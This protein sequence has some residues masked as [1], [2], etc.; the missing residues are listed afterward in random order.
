MILRRLTTALRKQDWVTVVIETLIVVFG[1]F[2]G[3]QVNNWNEARAERSA[4]RGTLIRLH[5]DFRESIAGQ[6]RDIHFLEQQLADQA[7]ILKSLDACA[8]APGDDAAFQRGIATIGWINPPRL[9]RR[10]IDE[11]TASG[12]TD[13]ISSSEIAEELAR[14]IALV[15]WRASWFDHTMTVVESYRQIIEPSIRYRMDRTIQNPFVP[16]HRGGVD[17]DIETL[18]T[19]AGITNAISA[20]SYTTSERL[21]AYRPILDAYAAFS[22][23]V[24]AELDTRWGVKVSE[25]ASP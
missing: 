1:V 18:C 21:E 8:V 9:Y 16:D 15:E 23:L 12:R 22:P 2:I 4:E 11:I 20:V 25:E 10:T 17:Y 13:I 24:A 6:S 5:E 19:D 3:L 14:T 7:L